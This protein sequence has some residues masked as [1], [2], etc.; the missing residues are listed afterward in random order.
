MRYISASYV[1]TGKGEFLKNGIV[2]LD[3]NNTISEIIDTSGIV[4]EIPF[5]EYF[6]GIITPGFINAHCHLEL[7]YM[8]NLFHKTQ[9]L[10]GFIEQML[11][12]KQ[13]FNKEI[14]DA[15][16]C[17]D[18]EMRSNGIVA[19]GDI[20]NTT[21]SFQTKAK[22]NILY[23]TFI[24]IFGLD[25]NFTKQVFNKASETFNQA[26]IQQTGT[27]SLVPHAAYSVEPNLF[28]EIAKNTMELNSILSIHNQESKEENMIFTEITGSLAYL[29]KKTGWKK[30]SFPNTN[31]SSFASISDYLP[32]RNPILF[33]HNVFTSS[34]DIL[35]AQQLFENRYWV[36][37]PKSNLFI[38]NL[39]P[40]INLFKNESERICLGTDSLASNDSL[41][42]LEEMKT[43]QSNFPDL[44]LETLLQW[45]TINGAKSLGMD[46]LVGSFEKGKKSGINLIYNLD[47]HHK[48]LTQATQVKVLA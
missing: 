13:S 4:K 18:Y 20:S 47:M 21:D 39:L 45:G 23:H 11:H 34:Q 36:F 3:N 44:P 2:V 26:Q 37:C 5:L 31:L 27:V 19:C 16:E 15:I 32:K 29:L 33:V 46:H 14:E 6:N 24:E 40:D 35:L 22:S 25:K 8:R 28:K 38:S 30:E 1:F 10:S 12:K 41:S 9:N 43:L 7:S 17:A 42:I 48:Q